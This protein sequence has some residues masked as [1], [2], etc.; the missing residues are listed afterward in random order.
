MRVLRLHGA[1]DVRIHEEP[2]PT[3][4]P[5]EELVRVTAV[6]LCGSDLH[7]YEDGGIGESTVGEPLVLGHELGGVI[8]TGPRAGERVIVEPADPC[9]VCEVCQAGH[10]NLCPRVRFLGHAPVHGGLREL[11]SWPQ[12]LLLPAPDS[13]AGDHVA[14]IEPLGIGLH[15]LDL[16]HFR[17]GMSAG[18]FGSGPIGL[19]L[20]RILKA[21]GATRVIATDAKPHRVQAALDSGADE[22]WLTPVD[23]QPEGFAAVPKVDVGF[24]AA[25]EDAALE[26]A[27]IATR[28]GGRVVVVGIP[29][30]NRHAFSAGEVR[31]KGLTVAWS[32]RAKAHHMLRAIELVD[33]GL[34]SLEGLIS[35]TYA[36]EDAP[37]AFRDLVA[38]DGLKIVIKPTE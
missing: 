38:R 8:A 35:S 34:V 10:A 11:M 2:E 29:P 19:F 6:G 37:A 27:F 15:G 21:L 28:L 31:R 14:L 36:L 17:A 20:I 12:R 26:S 5:G 3:P 1:G 24:E 13:V 18:V 33:H 25:G 22:A 16:G 4:G 7:W 23:G 9:G 30:T 32:R